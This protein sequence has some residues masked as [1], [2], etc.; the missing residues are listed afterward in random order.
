MRV[1]SVDLRTLSVLDVWR[2]PLPSSPDELEEELP[3]EEDLEDSL[4]PTD[5][6]SNVARPPAS[7]FR[8]S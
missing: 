4:N 6:S 1:A 7:D 3:D 2:A 5:V 8:L